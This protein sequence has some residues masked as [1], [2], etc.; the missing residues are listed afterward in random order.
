MTSAK[1]TR[2]FT[3]F[4]THFLYFLLHPSTNRVSP[5]EYSWNFATSAKKGVM[6]WDTKQTCFCHGHQRSSRVDR[7]CRI[8]GVIWWSNLVF[9]WKMTPAKLCRLKN[10]TKALPWFFKLHFHETVGFSFVSHCRL[11]AVKIFTRFSI[12]KHFFT[13]VLQ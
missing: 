8:Q 12:T 9:L 6:N 13:N 1:S 3:S 7:T 5:A 2:R 11:I 4:A 10:Q